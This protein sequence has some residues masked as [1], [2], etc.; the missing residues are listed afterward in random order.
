MNRRSFFGKLLQSVA[1]I[2]AVKLGMGNLAIEDVV[3]PVLEPI[4]ERTGIYGLPIINNAS[5]TYFG[6]TRVKY[7]LLGINNE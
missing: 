7:P 4:V 5:G 3:I 6:M 1:F 2:G